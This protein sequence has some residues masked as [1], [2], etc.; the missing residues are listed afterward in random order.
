MLRFF[1]AFRVPALPRVCLF[2]LTPTPI[3]GTRPV[4]ATIFMAGDLL[5]NS[6]PYFAPDKSKGPAFRRKTGPL[7]SVPDRLSVRL[8]AQKGRNVEL[9][10]FVRVMHRSRTAVRVEPLR[11]G[12]AAVFGHRLD[13]T[14]FRLAHARA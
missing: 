10:L 2:G 13:G 7:L 6:T 12:A 14:A 9:V 8:P 1:A 4:A 5:T 11:R 3:D